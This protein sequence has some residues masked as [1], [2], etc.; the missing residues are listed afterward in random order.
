VKRDIECTLILL[1]T[2]RYISRLLTYLLRF[3]CRNDIL[4]NVYVQILTGAHL[5]SLR[6]FVYSKQSYDVYPKYA[7]S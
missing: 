2:W 7:T 1:K 3:L 6:M 4:K 5:A